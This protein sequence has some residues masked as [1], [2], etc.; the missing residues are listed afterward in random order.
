MFFPAFFLQAVLRISDQGRLCR[1]EAWFSHG[2]SYSL[3]SIFFRFFNS[4]VPFFFWP[5]LL[6]S[7]FYLAGAL[8]GEPKI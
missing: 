3:G 4:I 5:G 1:N 8:Q 7:Y 2:I 6:N